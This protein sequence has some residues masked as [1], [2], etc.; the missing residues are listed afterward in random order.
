[1]L[2]GATCATV[3]AS[4]TKEPSGPQGITPATTPDMTPRVER[5]VASAADENRTKS[6]GVIDA[7]SALWYIEAG[8]NFSAA[9]AWR[10]FTDL[11][12]DSV[13]LSLDI[14][15]GTV[16]DDVVFNAY[17]ILA[18]HLD[19][20]NTEEQHLY[21][22]DVVEPAVASNELLVRYQVASGYEKYNNPPNIS[23]PSGYIAFWSTGYS[24]SCAITVAPRANTTIQQRINSANTFPVSP[25]QFWHSVE[26]WTVT[27][28]E[29]LIPG[30]N[31]WWRDPFLASSTPTNGG[32][33]E[34]LLFSWRNGAATGGLCLNNTEMAYWTGNASTNGTWRGITK[35]RTTH[36][37]TKVF[38]S[39]VLVGGGQTVIN[40]PGSPLYWFHGGQFTFGILSAGSSS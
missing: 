6:N 40:L 30:K 28:Y 11:R 18:A 8:L 12:S 36:C 19:G 1:M 14:S 26:S 15:A 24:P 2:L 4:C 38:S 7:D 25:G 22:V 33:R 31:Y 21:I 32:Y 27:N 20:V 3:L 29:T 10:S 17:G 37:P 13:L 5:F 35:I 39:C 9:Q 34:S 16:P 23:Y